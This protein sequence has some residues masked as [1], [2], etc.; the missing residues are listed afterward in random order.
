VGPATAAPL[1]A[2]GFSDVHT[3]DGT[4]ES[5]IAVIRRSADR[6][7]GRLVYLSGVDIS[8]DIGACLA[9]A[10]IFVDRVAVYR[11]EP[12]ECMDPRISHDIS[13][14]GFDAAVFLSVRT[15]TTFCRLASAAG[16]GGPCAR[17]M[18]VAISRKVA[19]AL[20]PAAF[21]HVAVAAT[22]S[23]DGIVDTV[24]TLRTVAATAR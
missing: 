17:M 21:R 11:A 8:C 1:R 16:I 24:L 23:L 22:P 19:E 6:L 4:A 7:A 9:P 20:E 18:G 3:A 10:G 2:A 15:A 12:A 13:R 5:L 14:N